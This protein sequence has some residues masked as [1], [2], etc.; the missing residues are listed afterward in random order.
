[1]YGQLI[2]E[3]C[4]SVPDEEGLQSLK[5]YDLIESHIEIEQWCFGELISKCTNLHTLHIDRVMGL[6]AN[7]AMFLDVALDILRTTTCLRDLK[8]SCTNTSKEQGRQ[9]LNEVVELA[10]LTTLEHLD[11]YCPERPKTRCKWFEA[12]ES[13]PVNALVQILSRQAGL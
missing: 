4:A 11:L 3:I 7:T 12:G 2:D 1:M 8:L 5:F 10:D 13:E 9:F 6:E